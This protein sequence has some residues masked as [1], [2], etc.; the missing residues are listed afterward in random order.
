M[1]ELRLWIYSAQVLGHRR[2]LLVA[3]TTI[4]GAKDRFGTSFGNPSLKN[5]IPASAPSFPS[6][7]VGP[8]TWISIAPLP[9]SD[10]WDY[11]GLDRYSQDVGQT[12]PPAYRPDRENAFLHGETIREAIG[13]L[14]ERIADLLHERFP[15][16]ALK[17]K[18][19]R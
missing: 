15:Q 1:R 19:A 16:P 10:P 4:G 17:P 7:I 11:R 14:S 6:W 13:S 9:S 12:Q 2:A 18:P 8:G 3:D 5:C